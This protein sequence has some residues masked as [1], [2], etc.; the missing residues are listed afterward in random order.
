MCKVFRII[1]LRSRWKSRRAESIYNRR[2]IVPF[3]TEEECQYCLSILCQTLASYWLTTGAVL[4]RYYFSVLVKLWSRDIIDSW[5]STNL[6]RVQY[7]LLLLAKYR[8]RRCANLQNS[9]DLVL[10]VYRIQIL[11]M[12]RHW[13]LIDSW[14]STG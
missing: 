10:A 5:Y 14:R 8:Q 1:F 13:N 12:N 4:A 11:A 6:Q 7:W 3:V 2:C 9:T